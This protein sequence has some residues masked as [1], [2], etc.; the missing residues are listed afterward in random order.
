MKTETLMPK[1]SSYR[2]FKPEWKYQYEMLQ[3]LQSKVFDR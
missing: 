1:F 3:Q 2:K